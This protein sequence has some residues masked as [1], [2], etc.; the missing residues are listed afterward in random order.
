MPDDQMGSLMEIAAMLFGSRA[1]LRFVLR[2][3]G[4]DMNED[5]VRSLLHSECNLVQEP[6]TG[7]WI[8]P[9]QGSIKLIFEENEPPTA[10]S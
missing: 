9:I 1:E 10:S 8:Q 4:N 7:V 3:R 2:L 6:C 5:A